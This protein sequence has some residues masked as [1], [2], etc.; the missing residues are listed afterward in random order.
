MMMEKVTESSADKDKEVIRTIASGV[1]S[2][3]SK[4]VYMERYAEEQHGDCG[5]LEL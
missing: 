4:K 1:N 5:I 3:K 2:L